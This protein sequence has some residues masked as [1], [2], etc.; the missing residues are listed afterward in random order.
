[1]CIGSL[2]GSVVPQNMGRASE[3]HSFLNNAI[4]RYRALC[5]FQGLYRFLGFAWIYRVQGTFRV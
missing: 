5:G 1:M 3:P 2:H 4:W